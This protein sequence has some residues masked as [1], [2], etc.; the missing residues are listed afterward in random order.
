MHWMKRLAAALFGAAMLLPGAQPA[1]AEEADH[2][3]KIGLVYNTSGH[4]AVLDVPSLKGARLA[5]RQ[6]NEDGG[7]LG[8]GLA[9]VEIPGD[10]VEATL[11][12]RMIEALEADRSIVGFLGLS[13]TDMVLAAATTAAA[14]DRVFLTSGATS[15]RLP[16]QVPEYLFL[17]CFGDNVQA[18]AAAEWAYKKKG[19]RSVTVLH[20]PD[21]VYTRLLR[22]YFETRFKELGGRIV[23]SKTVDPRAED[24]RVPTIEGA[25]LVFLSARTAEDAARVIND[26]RIDGYAGPVL[27]GDGYDA[28]GVWAQ[29]PD[30]TDI[31]FSTHAYIG[32]DNPNQEVREFMAAYEAAYPGEVPGAF[33]A[34]GYDAAG[35]MVAALKNAGHSDRGSIRQ[36]LKQVRDYDGLTGTISFSAEGRIPS[37]SVTIMTVREGRQLFETELM[38]ESFPAP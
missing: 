26:M 16:G 33:A 24:L 3:I 30:L 21:S 38:P 2:P 28:T 6:I 4:Q 31:Y 36:G 35:L 27:G 29:H 25:D 11:Q 34:L 37:K 8:R 15:P 5:I 17:A 22:Q 23:A 7:V 12:Q 10:S 9:P 32:M 19:A 13:N 18:A 14:M 20:D 1:L